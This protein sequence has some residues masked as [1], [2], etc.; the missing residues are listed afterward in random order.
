MAAVLV[1]LL[2]V[3][4]CGSSSGKSGSAS[5]AKHDSATTVTTKLLS[6]MP[7]TLTV[8]AGTKV[9]WVAGDGIG[10]TVTTGTFT[11]GSDGLRTAQHP[12]GKVNMPL[13]KGHDVSYTFTKPGKYTYYCSIHHGM[14]GV[15]VVTP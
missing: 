7:G 14:N 3:S 11:V 2:L 9:T 15:I 8:K 4:A 1:A 10:H 12:D 6:F 5:T 13:S